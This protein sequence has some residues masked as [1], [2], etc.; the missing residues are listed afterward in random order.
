MRTSF[1]IWYIV[2]TVFE[3]NVSVYGM[4]ICVC[5]CYLYARSCEIRVIFRIYENMISILLLKIWKL[6][7]FLEISNET[8]AISG[9][10]PRHPGIRTGRLLIRFWVQKSGQTR[11]NPGDLAG[12]VYDHILQVPKIHRVFMLDCNVTQKRKCI[13][14][15]FDIL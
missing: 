10:L 8:W 14:R 4:M 11:I 1:R 9:F 12:L 3:K 6:I 2:L 15:L 7:F 5:V 13:L